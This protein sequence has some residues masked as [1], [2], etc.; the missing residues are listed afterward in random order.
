MYSFMARSLPSRNPLLTD[1]STI[2]ELS[3]LSRHGSSRTFALWQAALL[4]FLFCLIH[5]PAFGQSSPVLISPAPGSI[6]GPAATFTWNAVAGPAKYILSLG[7]QGVGSSDLYSSRASKAT[8]V[9]VSRLPQQGLTVYA[10]LAW[11][12][13]GSWQYADYTYTE[14]S[15]TPSLSSLTCSSNSITGAGADSCTVTLSGPATGSGLIVSLSS[16]NSAVTVPASITIPVNATT[17]AFSAAVSAVNT[18]QTATLTASAAGISR[19]FVIQLGAATPTLNINAT[20]ISFGNVTLNTTATQSIT[21]SS[22]GAA[23]VTVNSAAITGAG[24]SFSGMSLPATLNPGQNAVLNVA[25]APTTSGSASGT[26][27]ISSNSTTNPSAKVTLSGTGVAASYQVDLAWNAPASSPDPVAGYNIYR[28][29]SGTGAYQL[30]NSSP[31]TQTNYV[32]SSVRVGQSYDY[33][34]K[35]VDSSGVEST[36]SN[37][38]TAVIP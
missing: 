15:S 21:L 25:F 24:F 18:A 13:K 34:V 4:G 3:R 10:R 22:T 29:A 27:T 37:V 26:V 1:A 12:M 36:P 28:A 8:S 5:V 23:A 16:N 19:T 33:E 30:L 11:N 6:L 2:T 17:A 7:T 9:S 31:D 38:T 20:A 32:D 14:A 35:S